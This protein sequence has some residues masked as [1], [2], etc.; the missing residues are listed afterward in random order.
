M[1]RSALLL[2][3]VV[4]CHP[5]E[6]R[7][8]RTEP[9]LAS[10]SASPTSSA[11]TLRRVHYTLGRGHFDFEL[12]GRHATPRG[13]LEHAR[14]ELDVDLDDL[15]HTTGRVVVDLGEL[16]ML[17]TD[18]AE[19][20]ATAR[21]LD[22]LELGTKV[23]GEKRDTGRNAT[24]A[25]SALDA[26]H[27]VS[28]PNGDRRVARRELVS[29]WTVRGELSLHGV[30]AP[31]AADVT[32]TLVPGPTPDGPPVELVIRSRRPLVVTLGTH[33]IRPRDERGVPVAKDL[34]LLGDKVGSEAKVSFELAFAPYR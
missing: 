5:S 32:L 16:V 27:L 29:S 4:A 22:W 7:R 19:A 11:P 12:P 17:G 1:L 3:S 8:E 6:K 33:D 2:L 23:S 31:L 13:K 15:S 14:G 28:A 20:T 34:P 21:A 9:W 26:G 24:F 25:L 30:R 10:A 18:G